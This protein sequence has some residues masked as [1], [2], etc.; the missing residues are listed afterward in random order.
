[1]GLEP[2]LQS[3]AFLENTVGTEIVVLDPSSRAEGGLNFLQIQLAKIGD[4]PWR[5]LQAP[6]GQTP[7]VR[8]LQR[9]I[10][11]LLATVLPSILT[12]VVIG[13][14]SQAEMKAGE[15]TVGGEA[16]AV[17]R[18]TLWLGIVHSLVQ[19][20]IGV[21]S[22]QWQQ[23][24]SVQEAM[25]RCMQI[26][27]NSAASKNRQDATLPREQT[28]F[29]SSTGHGAKGGREAFRKGASSL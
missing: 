19:K 16:A 22:K 6:P 9:D 24:P 11:R 7:Q 12:V 23:E 15:L 29:S 21:V 27:Y 28:S 1:M 3:E 14:G 5:N 25:L 8:V 13:M 4:I 20:A 2:R 17:S 18:T 26:C 10:P